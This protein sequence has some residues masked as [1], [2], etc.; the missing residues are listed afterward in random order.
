[1]LDQW[2]ADLKDACRRFARAKT[3]TSVAVCTLAL[4]FS[5]VTL[6]FALMQG[7]L[8]RP[9]PIPESDR[10]ILASKELRSSGF[11]NY[12]FGDVQID[13]VRAESRLLEAVGGVNR[14]GVARSVMTVD[15]TASYASVGFVMGGFFQ[16]LGV[17]PL[18]GRSLTREDDLEGAERVVTV[19]HGFWQRRYGGALDVVGRRITLS[20]RPFTIVGVMPPG[21]DYP[22]GVEIWRATRSVPA[23]GFGSAARSEVNL[24]GRMAPGVTVDQV[25]DELEGLTR[26]FEQTA[27]AGAGRG[28]TPVVRTLDD[29]ILGGVRPAMLA[30][31]VAVGLVTLIAVANV[32]NLS[33]VQSE[34]RRAE[35]AVRVALGASRGRIVRPF[36]VQSV[37]LGVVAS[38]AGVLVATWSLPVLLALAPDRLPRIETVQID[39]SVLLFTAGL[40]VL[41]TAVVGVAPALTVFGDLVA[42]VRNGPREPTGTGARRGRRGLV[43]AQV[44]LAV[45]VVAAASVVVQRLVQLQQVNTGLADDRLMLVEL[46]MPEEYAGAR[47]HRQF[48]DQVVPALEATAGIAAVTAVNNRPFTG[49]GWDVPRFSAEGQTT[50]RA[51]ENPSLN[52][53]SVDPRYFETF[54]IPLVAGRSFAET[55]TEGTPDVAIVSQDVAAV[56]WPG[57]QPLGKRLKMGAPDGPSEWLTVVGVAASTRYR[58]LEADRPTLYL[59]AAQFLDTAW[60]LVLQTARSP[61]DVADLARD[62]ARAADPDVEVMRVL[63]FTEAFD[64]PLARPRF[65]ALLLS[66]F[67][68]SALVL[69]TL[70]LY[71][72][73]AVFVRQRDSEI[74]VRIALGATKA[75]IQRLVVSE[76]LRLGSLWGGHRTCGIDGGDPRVERV[77]LRHAHRTNNHHRGSRRRAHR[78]I[79]AGV[80]PPGASSSKRRNRCNW[81]LSSPRTRVDLID[82]RPALSAGRLS[83]TVQRGRTRS[84]ARWSRR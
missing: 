81:V 79:A 37:L 66:A 31:F 5:A 28:L 84:G 52:L 25:A 78:R 16:V 13:E 71:A 73:V 64:R 80:I 46:A 20:E 27:P 58:D 30:L 48:L 14:N 65:Q 6:I 60:L 51:A 56:T 47:L 3:A 11:T 82:N 76:G 33:L 61:E 24:V 26:R 4:G 19:S 38:I 41:T 83:T 49:T 75:N 9:L 8:L 43:V 1:M 54:D 42:S 62:R 35:L 55:D 53:E 39:L 70:G 77:R 29:V 15:G 45:M 7:V 63:P 74:G 59:P 23:D 17:E 69:A 32:A 2:R 72:V 57:E 67:G 22:L 18:L 68:A 36:L 12:P 21:L 34:A 44:A 10:V 40:T 50:E